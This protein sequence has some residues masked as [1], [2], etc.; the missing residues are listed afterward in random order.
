MEDPTADLHADIGQ[1]AL[2][3]VRADSAPQT[4]EPGDPQVEETNPESQA[5]TEPEAQA[6]PVDDSV[7]TQVE[8]PNTP[9]NQTTS[10]GQA[11]DPSRIEYKF[12]LEELPEELIPK[13]HELQAGA[14]RKFQEIAPYRRACVD[15]MDRLSEVFGGREFANPAEAGAAAIEE[16][17]AVNTD[18]NKALEW[19]TSIGEALQSLGVQLPFDSSQPTQQTPADANPSAEPDIQQLVEQQLQQQLAPF[20]QYLTA[21]QQAQQQHAQQE[22]QRQQG[23]A[24]QASF[25]QQIAEVADQL[26]EAEKNMILNAGIV[27]EN[28]GQLA[29]ELIGERQRRVVEARRSYLNDK[30]EGQ[31]DIVNNGGPAPA[32]LP[33]RLDMSDPDAL[34]DDLKGALRMALQAN[35]T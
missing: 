3:A 10:E 14:T 27:E 19:F 23:L 11:D 18:P 21:Q 4:T 32:P 1:L 7:E 12:R 15:H 9:D 24:L 13:Y 6:E 33:R 5:T 17:I 16:L 29:H 25:E 34:K 22:Q 20:Q 8:D 35:N 2:D 26:S 28:W 30:L 31:P